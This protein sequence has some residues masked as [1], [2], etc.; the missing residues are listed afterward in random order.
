MTEGMIE[1]MIEGMIEEMIEGRIEELSVETRN[2]TNEGLKIRRIGKKI[3]GRRSE[4][5]GGTINEMI[6]KAMEGD[7]GNRKEEV[8]AKIVAIIMEEKGKKVA[9]DTRERISSKGIKEL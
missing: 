2:G 8:K 9:V 6:V 3:E 1:E 5:I 7:K 4:M